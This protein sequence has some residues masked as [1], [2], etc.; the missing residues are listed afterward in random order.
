MTRIDGTKLTAE[1][2]GGNNIFDESLFQGEIP[3][4]RSYLDFK[5]LQHA[6]GSLQHGVA[7]VAVGNSTEVKYGIGKEFSPDLEDGSLVVVDEEHILR[8]AYNNP[9]CIQN[10][11]SPYEKGPVITRPYSQYWLHNQNGD[12]RPSNI[13]AESITFGD[14]HALY[15]RCIEWGVVVSRGKS[16][17]IQPFSFG[18]T[19]LLPDGSIHTPQIERKNSA[20]AGSALLMPVGIGEVQIEPRLT[21]ERCT[22]DALARV[23]SID[24]VYPATG[25]KEPKRERRFGLGRLGLPNVRSRAGH[26]WTSSL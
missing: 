25:S 21:L 5:T 11:T 19:K 9:K 15:V 16:R 2:W 8:W 6:R 18:T 17:L 12:H 10:N 4:V 1:Y 20:L 14:E 7:Q 24:V 13:G 26:S 3:R 23:R 22:I